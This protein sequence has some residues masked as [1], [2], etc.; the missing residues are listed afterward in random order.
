MSIRRASRGSWQSA[1]VTTIALGWA[2][3][4][5]ANIVF[6]EDHNMYVCV[7]MRGGFGRGGTTF[8]G[9]YL[10]EKNF[11]ERILRHESVHADQWARYGL[12]FMARYLF[13]EARHPRARNKFEIE[14]GLED[15]NYA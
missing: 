4:W 2:K 8:G 15:G 9:A 7:G 12:T 11:G 13:E 3:L 1:V 14:A 10:T 5:R 6:D